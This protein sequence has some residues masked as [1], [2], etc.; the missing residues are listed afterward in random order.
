M[1]IIKQISCQLYYHKK[2]VI[3]KTLLFGSKLIEFEGQKIKLNQLE[4]L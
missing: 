4:P 3:P 1:Q 2:I